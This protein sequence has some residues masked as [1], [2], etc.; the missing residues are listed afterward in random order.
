LLK[1][2][3]AVFFALVIC[4][5]L[6]QS[7]KARDT[8]L[9]G[10][11]GAL[12]GWALGD[13]G[14]GAVG[15]ITGEL[16][17]QSLAGMG[18]SQEIV[19]PFSQAASALTAGALNLDPSVAAFSG[20]IAVQENVLAVV[21]VVAGVA[22]TAYELYETYDIYSK[23]G[24]KAALQHVGIGLAIGAAGGVTIKAAGKA[25]RYVN[26]QTALAGTPGLQTLMT[27]LESTARS[28]AKWD[29]GVTH[30]ISEITRSTLGQRQAKHFIFEKESLN[31]K[32]VWEQA[33][34]R[35]GEAI[36][37]ALGQNLHQNFPVIDKV[38]D[39]VATSIKSVDL[40][41]PTYQ[42]PGKLASKLKNYVDKV[43]EFEWGRV[44][45]QEV[46]FG[47][48]FDRRAL[49]LAVP[50]HATFSQWRVLQDLRTYSAS[51]GVELVITPIK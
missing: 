33:P 3:C 2:Y 32:G 42:D 37:K 36:E 30:K 24:L 7:L 5:S 25:M 48:H 15:A 43:A 50:P 46:Q 45:R 9:H 29:A 26:W 35:R 12:G 38:K 28:V 4:V 18:F 20:G 47:K 27:T 19:Q 51:K 8:A 11:V 49:E 21:L 16:M 31:L 41:A 14:A 40:G 17:G 34:V 44:L 10:G 23:H 22:M 1:K 13:P 39:R 6:T